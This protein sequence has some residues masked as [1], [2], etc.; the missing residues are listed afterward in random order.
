MARHPA[1]A[2]APRMSESTKRA[3]MWALRYGLPAVLV[4]VGFV[5]LLTVEGSTRWDGFAM[6]LGSALSLLFFTTVFRLGAEGDEERAE[7]EAARQY[8]AEHGHWPDEPSPRP[9]G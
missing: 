3:G 5:I 1:S 4:V 9:R 6:C 8:L 2:Y 7:E